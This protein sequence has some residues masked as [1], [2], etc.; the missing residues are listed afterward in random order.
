M[1]ATSDRVEAYAKA[2]LEVARAEG[3]LAEVEDELFRFAADLRRRPTSCGM[4]LT[5]PNLPARPPGRGGRGPARAQG[6]R[7]P[8]RRSVLA[9]VVV[10][11][12]R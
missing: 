4:A 1:S 6:A 3:H 12:G 8:P 5:D 9:V 11:P 10:G 7:R 2:L